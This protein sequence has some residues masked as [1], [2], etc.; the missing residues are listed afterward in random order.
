MVTRACDARAH[1]EGAH[2]I[3][4]IAAALRDLLR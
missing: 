2:V 4:R 1:G 3:R